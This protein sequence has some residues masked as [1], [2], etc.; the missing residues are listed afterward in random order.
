VN[1]PT[2]RTERLLLRAFER[3]DVPALVPLIGAREVAA[4]TLRIP[5]PYKEEDAEI[6]FEPTEENVRFAITLQPEGGLI[7]GIGLRLD[8][9]HN[10]AELG[11]WIGFPYWGQGYATEAAR[12]V[13]RYGFEVLNL[14]RIY[15]QH[16]GSNP[17]SG[18]VLRKLGMKPEGTLPQHILKWGEYLDV[19]FYGMLRTDFKA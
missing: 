18:G 15:A 7:G 16:F 10:R 11:Y 8:A 19:A 14:H 6:L 5:H 12:A 2:L 3:W 9:P 17:T 1:I 4:T 13:V